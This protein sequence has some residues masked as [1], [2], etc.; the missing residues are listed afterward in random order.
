MGQ[1]PCVLDVVTLRCP[2]RSIAART[3]WDHRTIPGPF[4]RGCKCVLCEPSYSL[5]VLC[6]LSGHKLDV[7]S[8]SG[9]FD[10]DERPRHLSA[11][12]IRVILYV[13]YRKELP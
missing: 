12:Y 6:V 4:W 7:F 10:G 2:G 3:P 11:L 9:S 1:A 13:N 5:P 8:P